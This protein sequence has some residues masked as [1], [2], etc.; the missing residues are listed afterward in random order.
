MSVT[1]QQML[2][3]VSTLIREHVGSIKSEHATESFGEVKKTS[4]SLFRQLPDCRC[5]CVDSGFLYRRNHYRPLIR[6]VCCRIDFLHRI[7]IP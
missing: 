7:Y 2:D 3:N 1:K 5:S 6:V 4:L